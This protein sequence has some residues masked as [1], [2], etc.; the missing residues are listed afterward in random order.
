MQQDDSWVIISAYT[1]DNSEEKN[2]S[3][4]QKL[5][6]KCK[7]Y[8]F[9]QF[10]SIWKSGQYFSEQRSILIPNIS[11]NQAKELGEEFG[12]KTI[13]VCENKKCTEVCT[14]SFDVYKQSEVK[15]FSAG[16]IVNVF[17]VLGNHVLNIQ[18]AKQILEKKVH[19]SVSVP[20]GRGKPFTLT[21][22]IQIQGPRSSYFQQT[23][24]LHLVFQ[25]QEK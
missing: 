24:S 15:H 22:I 11:I 10:K 6:M 7:K 23:E 1:D 20:V 13:I 8:G 9:V 12:Q 4:M 2:I 25:C 19:G 17:N 18:L 3:Q 5:K 16:D 21:K 14:I